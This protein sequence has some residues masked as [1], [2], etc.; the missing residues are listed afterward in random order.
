M[1]K[2][3]IVKG[4]KTSTPEKVGCLKAKKFTYLS[5]IFWLSSSGFA[6]V[7]YEEIFPKVE[8]RTF[9]SLLCI[10]LKFQIF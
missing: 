5:F 6:T 10:K 3:L 9:R 7:D 8:R 1:V 4:I 2:L